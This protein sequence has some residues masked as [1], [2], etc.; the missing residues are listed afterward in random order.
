MREEL[1]AFMKEVPVAVKK[2]LPGFS[3]F[4]NLKPI[5]LAFA[6]VLLVG[7]GISY[8]AEGTLPG[9]ALYA[10][11]VRV[12]ENVRAAVA[13]SNE[14]QARWQARI[15]ERRVEEAEHLAAEGRL[16][17]NVRATI[18][19]NFDAF[20]E[21]A[22]EKISALE[23]K[24]NVDAAVNISSRFETALKV[25]ERILGKLAEKEEVSAEVKTE[26]KNIKEKVGI[27]AAEVAKKRADA[28]AKISAKTTIEAERS[29]VRERAAAERAITNVRTALETLKLRVSAE[30]KA[31]TEAQLA[32]AERAVAEA[33][34]KMA[35][36]AHGAAV[37]LF[38]RAT[39]IADEARLLL[40][41]KNNLDVEIKIPSLNAA[42][43][44][45]TNGSAQ[46][47]MG[48]EPPPSKDTNAQENK[49]RRVELKIES[50]IDANANGR[51]ASGEHK[52]KL[53]VELDL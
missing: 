48:T 11:K 26:I 53:E 24:N 28:E 50:Q 33:K 14:A 15:A 46:M 5:P 37:G 32:A 52:T 4:A 10:V 12:N 31:Q 23:T 49:Q 16:D 13:I 39:R 7:G 34:A 9:D 36:G 40:E 8:A 51:E 47:Q 27:K 43:E 25:H 45:Q 2:T 30:A 44:T 17:S 22:K 1:L 20:A 18:E 3:L 19:A 21:R 35:A 29:A 42:V 6:A 41:A 38:G